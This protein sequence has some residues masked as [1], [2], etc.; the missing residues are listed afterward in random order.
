MRMV[1]NQIPADATAA[2]SC[3]VRSMRCCSDMRSHSGVPYRLEFSGEVK[4]SPSTQGWS[5]STSTVGS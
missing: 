2:T 4:Y 5:Q 1:S 3:R